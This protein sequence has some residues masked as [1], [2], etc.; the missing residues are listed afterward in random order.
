MNTPRPPSPATR[1]QF[2]AAFFLGTLL[3]LFADV[4]ALLA[5]P[6][7][8]VA[9]LALLKWLPLLFIAAPSLAALYAALIAAIHQRAAAT[10][11]PRRYRLLADALATA[12]L[13]WQVPPLFAGPAIAASPLK[14]PLLLLALFAALSGVV[15]LRHLFTWLH[16]QAAHTARSPHLVRIACLLAAP[17]VYLVLRAAS[18]RILPFLYWPFHRS[19]ALL[20]FAIVSA[21]LF[22]SMAHRPL[23]IAP[24]PLF[25]ALGAAALLGFG[26]HL[27]MAGTTASARQRLVQHTAFVQPFV[28]ALYA[29]E[30]FIESRTS[31]P[32][33]ASATQPIYYA[34]IAFR[35]DKR[36]ILYITIDAMRAD[37]LVPDAPDDSP[38]PFLSRL[39]Q[40]HRCYETAYAPS[41]YTPLSIPAMCFGRHLNPAQ[42]PPSTMTSPLHPL[43]RAGYDTHFFFTVDAMAFFENTTAAP[44]V[45]RQFGF[46]NYSGD[47]ESAEIILPKVQRAL[48]RP[49]PSMVWVHLA[50]LHQPFLLHG[51]SGT[52][53]TRC[54]KDYRGQAACLDAELAQFMTWLAAHHP[55]AVWAISADHGESF[56]EHG[57]QLHGTT[58]YDEQVRVPLI[59]GG[60]GTTPLRIATPVSNLDIWYTLLQLAGAS[61]PPDAPALPT[62]DQ[63]DAQTAPVLLVSRDA[64]A[65]I[66]SGHKLIVDRKLGTVALFDMRNDPEELRSLSDVQPQRVRD[67]ARQMPALGCPHHLPAALIA[68]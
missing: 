66:A 52:H 42:P 58:L 23:R 2:A 16:A 9:Q 55:D 56:G 54:P 36:P 33:T 29:L 37:L 8:A 1:T 3:C 61:L 26:A 18:V 34:D 65:L 24:R 40:Q 32:H 27:V 48:S 64:C 59:A 35:G 57:T 41:N 28:P 5:A 7:S 17:G 19:L 22:V 30:F 15:L 14:W 21:L 60:P 62:G 43:H 53:N 49:G 50:D 67:M 47:Y 68:P 11:H 20:A 4:F 12:P 38:M 13:W 10:T 25:A 6:Q 45:Q 39:C 44:L 51:R 63:R 31:A 46:R